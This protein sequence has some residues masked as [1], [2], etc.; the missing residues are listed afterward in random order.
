MGLYFRQSIKVG[1]FRFNLSKSGFGMSAGVRGLRVG[2][3]PRSHYIH[4]GAGG[5]YYQ[6]RFGGNSRR[7]DTQASVAPNSGNESDSYSADGIQMFAIDSADIVEMNSDSSDAVLRDINQKAARMRF[8]I[9]LPLLAL[10]PLVW[11]L[12]ALETENLKFFVVGAILVGSIL[13]GRW[14]VNYARAT[15]LMYDFD[16]VT[17]AAFGRVRQSFERMQRASRAWH[18]PNAGKV[19][20]LAQWKRNAGANMVVSRQKIDL[21]LAVPPVIRSNID[22]P[23]IPVGRQVLY[24]FPDRILMKDRN[25]YSS[26]GYDSLSLKVESSRFIESE[27]LPADAKKVGETWKYVNKKGGPDKRFKDNRTL[28]ICLYEDMLIQGGNGI[29]E[30]IELSTVGPLSEFRDAIHALRSIEDGLSENPQ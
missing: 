5:F 21:G 27:A 24:F 7:V 15:V 26:I 28:P 17:Y 20:T 4:S 8:S 23:S 2:T 25:K 1:P 11:I 29:Q 12:Q 10:L 30:L 3:G 9:I 19:E 22:V 16:E 14:Y 6:Q 18:I 13:L